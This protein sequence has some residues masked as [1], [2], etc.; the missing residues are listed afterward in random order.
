M[1]YYAEQRIIFIIVDALFNTTLNSSIQCLA[2]DK[3]INRKVRIT[4][5]QLCCLAVQ[6][7]LGTIA[8]VLALFVLSLIAH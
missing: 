2:N 6:G 1:S 7:E 3:N 5:F 4:H 8:Q